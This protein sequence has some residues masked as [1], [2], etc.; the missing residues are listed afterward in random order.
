MSVCISVILFRVQKKI[1]L[2]FIRRLDE[3]TNKLSVWLDEY[4]IKQQ[5]II[6]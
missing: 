1:T 4:C 2:F 6:E 5:E 3:T